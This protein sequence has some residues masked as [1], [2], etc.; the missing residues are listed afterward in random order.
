MDTS[1]ATQIERLST[2]IL[3]AFAVVTLLAA[4]A[5]TTGA[6]V[7]ARY[8]RA[9]FWGFEPTSLR[10]EAAFIW[11]CCLLVFLVRM[12]MRW[13]ASRLASEYKRLLG[14]EGKARFRAF[15]DPSPTV[16]YLK[17]AAGRVLYVNDAYCK[18][19]AVR[20]E[21]V[22]G[23]LQSEAM[24]PA[25][26]EQLHANDQK[27]IESKCGRQFEESIPVEGGAMR[28]WLSFKFP[29]TGCDGE[30]FLGGI[31]IEITE[32]VNAQNAL[33]ES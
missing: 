32:I 16:A 7:L 19:F 27:V 2:R 3:T 25:T 17:D 18:V 11:G 1:G 21:Q 12:G 14:D 5:V 6:L 13:G 20:P 10:A 22:I 24:P 26:A 15:M 29:V 31:S 4:V 23:K 33:R 30:V 9:L 8:S 28:N